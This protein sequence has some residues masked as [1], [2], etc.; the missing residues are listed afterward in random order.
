MSELVSLSDQLTDAEW[1]GEI[2]A[3]GEDRGYSE[4]VGRHHSAVFIDESL[5]VL[6]VS[7]DT[8]GTEVPEV[9]ETPAAP[10]RRIGERSDRA[11]QVGVRQL[12][13]VERGRRLPTPEE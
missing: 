1:L 13:S 9:N 2:A 4:R 5:D 8:V 11:E 6:L 3:I 12:A 7:F 10:V